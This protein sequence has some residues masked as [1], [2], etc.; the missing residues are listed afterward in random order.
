MTKLKTKC[1]GN[2]AEKFA[3]KIVVPASRDNFL[4]LMEPGVNKWK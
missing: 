4:E 3:A 2:F 1:I